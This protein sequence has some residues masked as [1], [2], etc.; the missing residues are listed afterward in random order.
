MK[1]RMLQM[2]FAWLVIIFALAPMFVQAQ[3]KLTIER[4][5]DIAEENNPDLKTQRLN[6]ERAKFLLEAQKLSL[7]SRF[8]LDLN[9][10]SYEKTRRFDNRVSEWYTNETFSTQ[11]T[12]SV[13]QPILP[14]DGEITLINTFGWQDNNSLNTQGLS[15]SNQAFSNNLSLRLNQPIFT[16]N[17]RKMALKEI[18]LDYEN[19]RIN[20]ALQR[21]RTEQNITQQFYAVYM[22]KNELEVSR[23]ELKNAKENFDMMKDK[24]E[25]DM[26]AKEELF[27]AELNY[28]TAQ[29]SLE[30]SIVTLENRK[31]QL[32]QILGMALNENIDVEA[33]IIVS[34]VAVDLEQAI[35]YGL[36]SRMELRQ[37]EISME[38]AELSMITVKSDNEFSGNIGLSLGLTGDN[39]NFDNIYE[40]PTTSPRVML[41]FSVPIFDWGANKKKVNAQK[42]AQ[43]IAK[44][45][46]EN[47]KIDIE[48]DVRQ[49]WRTLE[50]VRLQIEIAE[51]KVNS[52]QLTYDIN[53]IR[54]RNGDLTGMQMSQFQTQLSNNKISYWQQQINYKI[55][56]LN[57]KILSLYDFE[58][59]E[60]LVPLSRIYDE[61]IKENNK[62]VK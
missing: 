18:E 39:K 53:Q 52:A 28:I 40:N 45:N 42:A 36:N 19:A 20:Y 55:Q 35:T 29:S 25:A 13:V 47:E 14:T 32:K 58:K 61:E 1:N 54:Y 50:N 30:G 49:T 31:D 24:V 26:S 21:L 46:Y 8:S 12:F 57:L 41:S 9:P 60:P 51:K 27:Q 11:G 5:L 22:A 6:F 16:Y 3:E 59:D 33:E 10:V 56:L 37:R 62:S 38:E 15:A 23:D 44:L 4:A 34:P 43:T 7:R 17:R 2:K 48:L